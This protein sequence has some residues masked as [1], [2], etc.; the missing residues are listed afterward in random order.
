MDDEVALS[1]VQGAFEQVKNEVGDDANAIK[2]G[3][4]KLRTRDSTLFA[5]FRRVGQMM[6]M[7]QQGH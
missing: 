1:K 4:R 6:E 2:E 3:L 5:A 7:A